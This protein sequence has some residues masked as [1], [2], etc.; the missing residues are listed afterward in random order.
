MNLFI[1]D[2]SPVLAA[3]QQ[4]D[5]HVRKMILET[6]QMLSTAHRLL[7]G[8]LTLSADKKRKHWIMEDTTKEQSLYKTTH[9]NHPCSKWVRESLANYLWAYE[10]FCGLAD[11]FIARTGKSHATDTKLRFILDEAPRKIPDIGLTPFVLA[12]QAHPECI[13]PG[14]PV[15]SYRALYAVKQKTIQMIWTNSAPPSWLATT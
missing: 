12:M 13:F 6:A 3:Q 10:H 8:T 7:D 1:L 15:R 5:I 2:E 14:E 9:A 11:E 4:A